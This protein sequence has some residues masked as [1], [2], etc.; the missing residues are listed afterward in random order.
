MSVTTTTSTTAAAAAAAAGTRPSLPSDQLLS[1]VPTS[2]ALKTTTSLGQAWRPSTLTG[3]D[4][5]DT[6]DLQ[7]H[8][9]APGVMKTGLAGISSGGALG[10]GGVGGAYSLHDIDTSLVTLHERMQNFES[11]LCETV[12][13][14][15]NLL[16]HKP[17]MTKDALDQL[18]ATSSAS[19]LR[20]QRPLRSRLEPRP[21]KSGSDEETPLMV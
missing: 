18:A 21:Q 11:E 19:A 20:G 6:H 15:L 8:R 17:R 7:I 4:L 5:Y 14:I 9:L 13:A 12:D 3:Y 16:G 1:T 2:Y 10:G